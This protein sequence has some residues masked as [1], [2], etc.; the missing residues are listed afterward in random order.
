LIDGPEQIENEWLIGKRTVGVTAGASA[1][2]LLVQ[3]V[4]AVL[5]NK[6]ATSCVENDGLRE[7][8]TFVLPSMLRRGRSADHSVQLA[9]VS[10]RR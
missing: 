3:R 6:G 4:V 10:E 7:N 5:R 8:V 9:T 1:P 2:E